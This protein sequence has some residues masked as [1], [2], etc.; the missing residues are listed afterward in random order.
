VF[1]GFAFAGMPLVAEIGVACAVAIAVDATVVR[2]VLVPAL[3]AMF[4]QWNWWLPGWLRR[5]LPSVDFE[6]P[7]PTV[8]LGDVVMIPDDTSALGIPSSCPLPRD[9][10][11]R[12]PGGRHRLVTAT[13]GKRSGRDGTAP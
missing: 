13:R 7:M 2:L 11:A 5:V 6:K 1:I 4:A 12:T 8:D 10:G 3:M 9:C